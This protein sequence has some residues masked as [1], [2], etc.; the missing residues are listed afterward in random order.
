MDSRTIS[1]RN[2]VENDLELIVQ[3]LAD[4]DLG[5]TR[6]RFEIPLPDS[7]RAAFQSIDNDPNIE[8]IV[9]YDD[10]GVIG[11]MQVT[12][13]PHLTYQGGWRATI[14]GV[15]THS[16]HRGQGVGTRLIREAIERARKRGCHMVQLTTNKGRVDALRF[17]EHLGFVAS[18]EGLKLNL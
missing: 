2:A 14:E 3:M 7:Y 18:H 1:F 11:V 15:R 8:L 9:A 13:T 5:A 16:N 17:Y 10:D 4:D 12:F 6:E